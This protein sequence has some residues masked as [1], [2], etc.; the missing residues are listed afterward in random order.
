[1]GRSGR[2]LLVVGRVG[3]FGRG[4]HRTA[5]GSSVVAVAYRAGG[6]RRMLVTANA[7]RSRDVPGVLDPAS[8]G[9]GAT[10]VSR[11]R[12]PLVRGLVVAGS[13]VARVG[14]PAGRH[15][16]SVG[17]TSLGPTFAARAL[18][19]VL[20]D[21]DDLTAATLLAVGTLRK[22][23]MDLCQ[24]GKHGLVQLGL[25]RM[26]SGRMLTQVVQS[27]EGL[28][29]VARE[30]TLASVLAEGCQ[31]PSNTKEGKAWAAG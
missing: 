21:L 9:T 28:A 6:A 18:H 5:A 31:S 22:R 25:V 17:R 23:S 29:T 2:P 26:D 19:R 30:R 27:R 15:G 8:R 1:M 16:S 11:W 3:V 7:A 24:L 12:S 20:R 13:S 14:V 10:V 4:R